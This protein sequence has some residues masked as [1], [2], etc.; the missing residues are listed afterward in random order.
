MRTIHNLVQGSPEWKAHRATPGMFNGSEIAAIMGLSSYVTRAE[1]LRRKATGIEP[2][3]DAATLDRFA[4]G[5]RREALAR[6]MAEDILDD[7]LS[8]MVMSDLFDGVLISVSLDGI[9]QAYDTTWE[10]K[11]LNITLADAL[12]AGFLPAEYHPQCES[13]LMV[14]GATRCL[15]VASKW[16][17]NGNLVDAKKTW[18]E[19][20]PVMRADIIAACKQFAIDL[21][22]YE[23]VEAVAAPVAA[24]IEALPGLFIQVEGKVLATNLDSFK[25]AAQTFIDGIKT[26]LVSDQDFADADK[27]VKFLKDGEERLALSKDQALAQTASIDELFRTVDAIS[28]Q[29]RVKRLALDKL[30]K[31]E[32]ENRRAEIVR[33]ASLEMNR[34]VAKLNERIGGQWM[35][36][37]NFAPFAE[38]VKGLK[39]LD[40]MRDKV[41]GE[42]ANAKIEANELA[43]Q[44]ADN[45]KAITVDGVN[46][47]YLVHDFAQICTKPTED[48][49]AIMARRIATWK[50]AEAVKAEAL[51]K[52][53]EAR[54]A[55]AVAAAVEAERMA[56]AKRVAEQVAKDQRG[57]A[58]TGVGVDVSARAQPDAASTPPTAEEKRAAIVDSQDVVRAYLNS[59]ELGEKEFN[60][61]RA[62]LMG[63]VQFQAQHGMKKD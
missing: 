56:E 55:A 62:V 27:M 21:A 23:H 61:L 12:D 43:D 20:N 45:T 3:Y 19:S 16:D 30:V 49:A 13:G 22:E 52:A 25:L 14:S 28:E 7:D 59:L 63:F 10:H 51:K 41:A 57:K 24:A 4:E 48:F 1:L 40:S 9:N 32:K 53:E 54:T 44:I 31:A 60:R 11:S 39:S 26:E 38:A 18:Y 2:E 36:V 47:N 17:T 50:E 34:H 46:Y 29:M 15:F 35:P 42:L 33:N 5:H 58:D 8:A 6:P 37:A